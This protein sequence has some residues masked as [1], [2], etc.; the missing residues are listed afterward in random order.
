MKPG[1]IVLLGSLHDLSLA[2]LGST[3]LI[4]GVFSLAAAG[5]AT[6]VARIARELGGTIAGVGAVV[7]ML[8]QTPVPEAF[9]AGTSMIVFFPLL[10]TGVWLFSRQRETAGAVVLCLAALIRIEAFAVLLG[11][12]SPTTA[13]EKVAARSS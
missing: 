9:R 1:L 7:Y 4:K 3:L 5:L 6:M 2:L 13:Q 10:L 11:W 8:T 12:R